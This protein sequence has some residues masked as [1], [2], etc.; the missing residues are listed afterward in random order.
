M[1]GRH[2]PVRTPAIAARRWR[3]A[4][5]V[6]LLLCAAAGLARGQQR[7]TEYE[8][9]AA[10]LYNFGKFVKWP[11]AK[12]G[13]NTDFVICVLGNDPFGE[14]LDKMISGQMID[15]K[16]TRVKRVTTAREASRCNIVYIAAN[17]RSELPEVVASLDRS[18]T[19]TVSDIPDFVDQGGMIEFV[20]D[21]GR[22]RFRINLAAAQQAG[23]NLS[24]ELL[25]VASAVKE[26]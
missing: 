21:S 7:A 5:I 8:V 17:E 15:G 20:L 9:K 11:A 2:S 4:S 23:L 19:L 22:V 12:A 1:E 13:K 25:K 16:S 3:S 10:Y 26:H 6:L 18:S 24:S 14:T